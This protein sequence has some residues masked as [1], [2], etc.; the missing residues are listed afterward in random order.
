MKKF[1]LIAL[2]AL[3]IIAALPAQAE[4]PESKMYTIKMAA[5]SI[6]IEV[7]E[8]PEATDNHYERLMMANQ[9]ISSP[10]EYAK[11]IAEIAEAANFGTTICWAET[12]PA[13]CSPAIADATIKNAMKAVWDHVAL[14]TYGEAPVRPPTE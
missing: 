5:Y 14:A 6:A 9:I 11:K 13:T 12:D 8:E 1:T 2:A 7:R 4:I 3:F 10:G